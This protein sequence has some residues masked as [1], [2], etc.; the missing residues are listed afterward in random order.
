MHQSS[1]TIMSQFRSLV[2]QH[3]KGRKISILDVGGCEAEGGYEK[4][5]SDNSL[6]VYARLAFRRSPGID[7]VPQN[8]NAWVEMEDESY[9]VII[10]G[11]EFEH[12]EFPW[13]AIREMT[14]V[15]KK[16]GLICIVAP[17]RGPEHRHPVDCWRYYP[18]GLRALA[19]WAGL[20][21]LEAKT[22][23][24]PTGFKDGSDQWGDSFCILWKK[25]SKCD[26]RSRASGPSQVNQAVNSA[27]PLQS[28]KAGSY[29]SFARGEIIEAIVKNGLAAS[30]VL[31]I[32]CAGG[33]TGQRLKQERQVDFYAGVEVSEQAALL[34]RQY[35]DKVIV[36]D[37]E[38]ADLLEHGLEYGEF[39]LIIALDVLEHLYNP[40]DVLAGLRRFLRPGGHVIASVPNVQNI[41]VVNSLIQGSW[42]YES[43]GILDATHLRFFTRSEI[44][45]LF[46]GAGLSLL[47]TEYVL[48][49][50]VDVSKIQ[51]TGNCLTH[52]KMSLTGL[53]REEVLR[54]FVYQYIIIAENEPRQ[55]KRD[56]AIEEVEDAMAT[57]GVDDG[58]LAAGLEV[59]NTIGAKEID[60]TEKGRGTLSLCM[61]VKNEEGNLA[62]CLRSMRR[63]ADEMI[64]VDTGSSDRTKDIARVFGAKV[65]DFVWTG[66]F[67]EARNESLSRASG[68]WI[69]TLDA[70]EVI[71]PKD[72]VRFKAL[73]TEKPAQPI[74]YA[75]TTRNYVAYTGMH[76]WKRN[77][78]SYPEE[79][80]NG[81]IPS[82]KV[83]LFSRNSGVSYVNP[84]HES[85]EPALAGLHI[86]VEECPIP[87]HH[88]G[89]LDSEKSKRKGEW[90]L[91][92]GKKKLK[93]LGGK[94]PKTLWELGIQEFVNGD[95][96]NALGWFLELLKLDPRLLAIDPALPAVHMQAGICYMSLRRYSDA[97]PALERATALDPGLKE[98][99]LNHAVT[100]L[101]LGRAPEASRPIE[102]LRS[103]DPDFMNATSLLGIIQLC[104]GQ[105][106]QGLAAMLPVKEDRTGSE[107]FLDA[108]MLELKHLG[109]CG[110]VVAVL[111]P[112]QERGR[113]SPE[114]SRLLD[115]CCAAG[116]ADRQ[117]AREGDAPCG[118]PS[119]SGDLPG[120]LFPPARIERRDRVKD[121]TSLVILTFNE[122]RYT[123]E[124]I[125]SIRRHTTQKHEII[126]IDNGSRDGT[127]QWLQK[128]VKKNPNYKLIENNMNLGFARGCN[129][130]IEAA[131]GE[132]ILLLNN[133]V[134]VT[135][136][137]LRRMK[138]CLN[139]APDIGI[140]GPMTNNIS[141]I[142][143]VAKIEY[144]SMDGLPEFAQIFRVK[145]RHRLIPSRR[146]VGFC[147]LFR[148]EL[149]ERVGLLD[150]GFGSGN[151]EDDDFCLR[152]VLEGYRNFIAG[153]VFIHHYGSRSFAGNKVDYVSAMAANKKIFAEKWCGIDTQGPLMERILAVTA[154]E[155]ADELRLRGDI[156]KAVEKYAEG[157]GH[158]PDDRA[159]YYALAEM[160]IEEKR[161]QDALD[162]LWTIPAGDEETRQLELIGYCK[163]GLGL[164][165]EAGAYADSALRLE[166]SSAA[167]LNLKGVLAFKRQDR[168]NAKD[169]F[170]KALEADPGYGEAHT[171]IGV[172]AWSEGRQ[173]EGL[174]FLEKGFILS[175]TNADAASAYY[176][177]VAATEAFP[178][179][180]KILREARDLYPQCRRIVFL[181]IDVL[182][183][184][185]KRDTA[186]EE[187]EDAMATFGVDDGIL[188]AGL[189]VR[190]TIGAKEIDRTEKGRGTLSLCMIVKNE[191]GNLARCLRSMRRLADEMIVVDTGSSDRTKDI[192]RVF[193]AKVYDFVWTGSFA[194]ARNESLS[195]ASGDWIFALDAD[196]VISPKDQEAFV[197]MLGVQSERPRAYAFDTRNYIDDPSIE[198]WSPN[199]GCYG[200]EEAGTGWN[201]S[202]KTRLFPNLETIRFANYVHE[203]VEASLEKAGVGVELC[204]IPVHHYGKLNKE[205]KAVKAEAYYLLGKKKLQEKESD[206]KAL[207]ELAVQAGE[208]KRHEEAVELW[209]RFIKLA[210][211]K[212]S[213][214]FNMGYAYLMLHK[215]EEALAAS[216]RAVELAPHSKEACINLAT[217]E[218]VVGN[219]EEAISRLDR[220]HCAFPEYVPAVA[221]LAVA[222]CR[223]E[224]QDQRLAYFRKMRKMG[225][226]FTEYI[227]G[228][229]RLFIAAG[230]V[231]DAIC[232]LEAGLEGGYR[233]SEMTDLMATCRA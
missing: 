37:I 169:F 205:S 181:L 118:S 28:G 71:S 80:G 87:I 154:R 123:K 202:R 33:A 97:L 117:E 108:I 178:G 98:V 218:L 128:L 48:N 17:S 59:R 115:E 172:L 135:E 186:I 36:A 41:T 125:E 84:V 166:Q 14:R 67:A 214:F 144:D 225:Y 104:N 96:Q 73:I 55:G 78:G 219:C 182:I 131:S 6:F 201:P 222:H 90:Y 127:V 204:P 74:A 101:C 30:R 51:E 196:E 34:A 168:R 192:A 211:H 113:L 11:Q 212:A 93:E 185:G 39:D 119:R 31:E 60:R 19:K 24:G 198:G 208:L 120:R 27:S 21:V 153:D 188:A 57:F 92:L 83:R 107:R 81:W 106:D 229:S 45:S 217:C 216:R 147:M 134:V 141:G 187:V 233:S 157:I 173:E 129:Q 68:D 38:S 85:L 52:E 25:E 158:A 164:D 109:H 94:N 64:V 42:K 215:F 227:C 122:L 183:R 142:Q 4:L 207:H 210:P 75:I 124:C 191:E 91:E 5:F 102:A 162:A 63:L 10:S 194:E 40:W 177:A 184:Q 176:S 180:E 72:Y 206:P 159:L 167:A 136:N 66:S 220:L 44:E 228:M 231:Q 213:A 179:A 77:D 170:E 149:V 43:A 54:F 62:R 232:L 69:F 70:D 88:Y 12:M 15:L 61:I 58:I 18:D 121:L 35:L 171:N 86:G 112:L 190:N 223:D 114:L 156:G 203:G 8:P 2:T 65:Y 174:G 47:K 140:V 99:Y 221:A 46:L 100:L 146:V 148:R 103:L 161:F 32:G 224:G 53:N 7:Y 132:Y 16:N 89:K 3:F 145:N 130:G 133:D 76:G 160:L 150:E 79:A 138:E 49:P 126:F 13:L 9:D 152:A 20:E 22:I 23:W 175:P 111:R 82:K 199:D 189:E 230:R 193:G 1:F 105:M 155:K 151:F 226:N 56:T 197:R 29:Y 110:Y 195:R 137:W 139:S 165:D 209:Q 26:Y 163:E 50:P 200:G 116:K 95:F 143:K